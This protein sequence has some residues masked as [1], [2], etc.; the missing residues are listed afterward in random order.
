MPVLRESSLSFAYEYLHISQGVC[1]FILR[2][3][4]NSRGCPKDENT[5]PGALMERS[6]KMVRQH[7][8]GLLSI[9]HDV[10]GVEGK[11][12]QLSHSVSAVKEKCTK[13]IKAL[14]WRKDRQLFADFCFSRVVVNL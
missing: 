7:K 14:F 12:K 1:G 2:G 4:S 9:S 5:S 6:M 13:N 11:K 10:Q 3:F 8:T